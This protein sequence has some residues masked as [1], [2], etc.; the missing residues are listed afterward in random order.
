[1]NFAQRWEYIE[2]KENR[3]WYTSYMEQTRTQ[4]ILI[5]LPFWWIAL[6]LIYLAMHYSSFPGV[7]TG[8]VG[9]FVPIGPF[10]LIGLLLLITSSG[11][12]K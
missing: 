8:F 11:M 6:T 9:L 10:N 2:E 1:M 12:V 7:F 3:I 5:S 4:K